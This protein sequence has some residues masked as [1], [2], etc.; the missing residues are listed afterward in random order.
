M[1]TILFAMAIFLALT[2]GLFAQTN[3]SSG[4]VQSEYPITGMTLIELTSFI[5]EVKLPVGPK[6]IGIQIKNERTVIIRTGKL[7][8]HLAGAGEEIVYEKKNGK[9]VE[10]SRIHWKS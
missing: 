8:G 2:F 5:N 4:G 1:K 9:W 7:T 3:V 6:I 10:T